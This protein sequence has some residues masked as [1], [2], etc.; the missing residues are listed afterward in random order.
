MKFYHAAPEANIEKIFASGIRANQKGEIPII[1][2]KDDF[3]LKKFIFDVYAHEVLGLDVY[4]LFEIKEE[5]I[6]G[7]LFEANIN[8]IF[9]DS[10]K[11]SK[12]PQ[13]ERKHLMPFKT[14]ESYEGMGL[15]DGVFPVENKDKFTD[16][17]K[18]K[19]LEYLK[20]VVE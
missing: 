3:L 18:R 5:G 14:D 17:Y 1:V 12:Q 9:S 20:E 11:I 6:R 10:F 13:I 19:V 16:Q 7:P 2:L 4:C 8:S 15:I